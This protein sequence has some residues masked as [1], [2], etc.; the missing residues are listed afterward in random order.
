MRLR[1]RS[2]GRLRS[3]HKGRAS[4]RRGRESHTP[5]AGRPQHGGGPGKEYLPQG[6]S[7]IFYNQA[8]PRRS[9]VLKQS[10]GLPPPVSPSLAL[11]TGDL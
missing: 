5:W 4:A 8:G 11:C 10:A 1:R 3:L 7:C 6:Y 2:Q 9:E